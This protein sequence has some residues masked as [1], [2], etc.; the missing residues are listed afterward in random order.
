[1]QGELLK[2]KTSLSHIIWILST[3]HFLWLY[4]TNRPVSR[5]FACWE[6]F[7]AAVLLFVEQDGVVNIY[8]SYLHRLA[9]TMESMMLEP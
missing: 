3:L 8:K 1:M 7:S 6:N 2:V 5:L 9:D 4:L